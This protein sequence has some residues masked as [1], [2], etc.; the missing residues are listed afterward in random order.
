MGLT[1]S[2]LHQEP[3]GPTARQQRSS[4]LTHPV[5]MQTDLTHKL[6]VAP[7]VQSDV[8]ST[9]SMFDAGA[10]APFPHPA[11]LTAVWSLPGRTLACPQDGRFAMTHMNNIQHASGYPGFL[12]AGLLDWVAMFVELPQGLQQVG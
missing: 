4:I 11:L 7:D 12:L 5:S 6:Y 1:K 2:A 3:L 10:Q 9:C 8:A